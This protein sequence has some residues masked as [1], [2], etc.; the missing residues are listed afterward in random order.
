M[1][2][3]CRLCSSESIFFYKDTQTYY[4]CERCG[5]I[6][7]QNQE[8]PDCVSE[9]KRY[10]LHDDNTADDGYRNFVRPLTDS[11]MNDF[12]PK[13][14][15]LDFGAGTSCIISAM[16][17][18]KD[19]NILNYDPYFHVYPELLEKKYDYISSCEVVEHFYTPYKEFKLLKNMLNENAKL[20]LM[21]EPYTEGIDFAR[22]YY[23]NDPTHVFFYTEKTFQWIKKEFGFS[24]LKVEKRLIVFENE[25]G[26]VC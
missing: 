5:G 3:A 11:I 21:T 26:D 12:T 14:N 13:D 4:K 23:K 24:S 8:L 20:Y 25:K 18:E 15:G 22:W 19:Y 10:E 16:L 17:R 1:S 9:K 2:V 6:F 7:V